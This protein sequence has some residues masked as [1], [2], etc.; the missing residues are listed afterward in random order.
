MFRI[1]RIFVLL[2]ILVNVA[3]GTWLA[4]ARTTSWETPL[5]VMVYPINADGSET[6]TRYIS[7]LN[8]ET[9]RPIEAFF[10]EEAQRI[11]LA[12]KD[13]VDIHMGSEVKMLPPPPPHGGKV[14][15]IMFWS[16]SLR[17]WAWRHA[18]H[19]G[20][21]DPH[22]RMFVLFYDP[23]KVERVAHSLGLQ[24]GLIGVVHAYSSKGQT[25]QNNVVL[26]HELFHT[27]GATDKYDPGTNQPAFPEGY[28]DPE[29]V[30]LLPQEF[31]ELMAGRMATSETGSQM[32]A[33][34]QHT[35]IG[36]KTAREIGWIR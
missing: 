30:P 18:E 3:L 10:D 32:P 34:L 14:V 5:R 36:D 6:T 19:P 13:L 7:E 12:K 2:V 15:Q 22:A 11:G 31:A 8:R 26:A 9:F 1:L 27:V 20:Q 17:L 25:A 29:K 33:S 24:K 21:P 4:R 23:A 28:A 35:V 16:L